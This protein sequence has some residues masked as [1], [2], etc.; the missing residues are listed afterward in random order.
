MS[1]GAIARRDV[2]RYLRIL[3]FGGAIALGIVLPIAAVTGNLSINAWIF[4]CTAAGYLPGFYLSHCPDK[5]YLDFEHG[6]LWYPSETAAIAGLKAADVVFLGNSRALM[7]FSSDVL[8]DG[9]RNIGLRPYNAAMNGEFDAFPKLL[10]QKHGITPRYVVIN[11]D[12]FFYGTVNVMGRRV[13]HGGPDVALEYELKAKVQEF[14]RALCSDV[15]R[16]TF[17]AP[18]LCGE[19]PA[20]FRARSDGRV[21][22]INWP[23][24]NGTPTAEPG[25]G[26]PTNLAYL[27]NNGRAFKAFVE[28]FGGCMILTNIISPESNPAAAELIAAELD[29][30]F[31]AVPNHGYSSFDGSHLDPAGAEHW[32][33]EFLSLFPA[34]LNACRP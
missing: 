26:M 17:P 21:V 33:M 4:R 20:Q 15:G 14:H 24:S 2:T 12:Y 22:N 8:F 7:G 13:L 16:E 1:P 19:G 27:I 32:G 28:A 11:A 9:M 18:W 25:R 30:P 34:A 3:L 29:V 31:V 10:M 6:A 23:T 5:A